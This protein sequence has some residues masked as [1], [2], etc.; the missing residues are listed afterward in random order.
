MADA[1]LRRGSLDGSQSRQILAN[2]SYEPRRRNRDFEAKRTAFCGKFFQL[3]VTSRR[4]VKTERRDVKSNY[5]K[6]VVHSFQSCLAEERLMQLLNC[7][8]QQF[9]ADT[10]LHEQVRADRT[11]SLLVSQCG[12]AEAFD[13]LF[14]KNALGRRS[15]TTEQGRMGMTAYE[16]LPEVD[17]TAR[18]QPEQRTLGFSG[19][20]ND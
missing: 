4:R 2:N 11:M 3:N 16:Q 14:L 9:M 6:D 17:Q 10:T 15:F 7:N 20:T 18:D 5:I 13:K 12:N 1:T 19:I 8:R